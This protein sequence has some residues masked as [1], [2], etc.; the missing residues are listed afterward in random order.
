MTGNPS[1]PALSGLWQRL[2]RQP[3]PTHS[4]QPGKGHSLTSKKVR[5]I[6]RRDLIYIIRSV[7]TLIEN[8]LSLPKAL[9]TIALEKTLKT[10]RPLLV[11][12][13][14]KVESGETFSAALAQCGAGLPE[15]LLNQIRVGERSG[16]LPLTLQRI[17]Q[18]LENAD[19]FK[20]Q[21]IKKLAYPTMLVT[22]GSG[23][24]TFMLLYVVP[25]FEK[26]YAES[27][28]KLPW[29]TRFLIAVGF[30][31][32]RY[33]W[34]GL[35]VI[36]GLVAGVIAVRRDPRGRFWMDA[37]L[38]RLPVIGDWLKNLA[39]LQF[40][41]V[42]GNLL[43]AGFTLVEALRVSASSIGNRAVRHSVERLHAAVLRGERF[44]VELERQA[45]LFPPI[46]H[47]LVVVGEKTGTLPRATKDIRKHLER[48]LN[49]YT[50]L[51]LGTIEP[52]MTIGLAVCI[53]GILLAIYLPMFDMIG[54]LNQ[55]PH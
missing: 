40:V 33:G 31:G 11:A 25:T 12:V 46:V 7:G 8:G 3:L 24:V 10:Y 38:L 51:L 39:V 1:H 5:P 47:Q 2:V 20:S 36:F 43:E 42:L 6:R 34:I 21:I 50:G 48:E 44:S 17:T 9:E 19:S 29:I 52:V 54:A 49:R 15:L 27:G 28:A 13:R 55:G 53:G 30:Y 32:T 41:E 37:Q 26:T 35:L 22:L 14:Q 23:A 16:T 4:G 45:D 18:Q